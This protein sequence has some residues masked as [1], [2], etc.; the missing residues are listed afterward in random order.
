MYVC[1]KLR[2]RWGVG[3][4]CVGMRGWRGKNGMDITK[5]YL[6]ACLKLKNKLKKHIYQWLY[7]IKSKKKNER[8]EI[9]ADCFIIAFI[10]EWSIGSFIF[11]R[12]K[13]IACHLYICSSQAI[14]SSHTS[15]CYNETY[16]VFTQDIFFLWFQY[17]RPPFP[18]LGV[19]TWFLSRSKEKWHL[20]LV[21]MGFSALSTHFQRAEPESLG[22]GKVSQSSCYWIICFQDISLPDHKS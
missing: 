16:S 10:D 18:E 6:Y 5:I 4:F 1:S 21:L 17:H 15:P 8:L 7:M 11:W 3:F 2:G 19:S 22:T 12:L 9:D 14:S 20:S 13:Q